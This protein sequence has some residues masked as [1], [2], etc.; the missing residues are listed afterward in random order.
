MTVFRRRGRARAVA[1]INGGVR[2]SFFKRTPSSSSRRGV[3]GFREHRQRF[4]N[5]PTKRRCARAKRPYRERPALFF[6]YQ[7]RIPMGDRCYES[8]C[9]SLWRSLFHPLADLAAIVIFFF[10]PCVIAS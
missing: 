7:N 9:W 5:A 3:T 1:E 4:F 8:S 2:G 10:L 6:S